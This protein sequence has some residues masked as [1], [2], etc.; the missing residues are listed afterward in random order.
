MSLLDP[1]EVPGRGDAAALSLLPAPRCG[2]LGFWQGAGP[3]P[4]HLL[5]LAPYGQPPPWL[6]PKGCGC[7][8]SRSRLQAPCWRRAAA[9]T[10]CCWRPAPWPPS[11]S[12]SG[13]QGAAALSAPLG[14]AA[15]WVHAA[16]TSIEG[17]SV[18]SQISKELSSQLG[19]RLRADCLMCSGCPALD[20]PWA[21]VI[22]IPYTCESLGCSA[23]G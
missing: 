22:R 12:A 10:V 4:W 23:E 1:R 5:R 6:R 19:T 11:V 17:L 8:G 14:R 3:F 20:L 18:Q 16:Q 9:A 15:G 7:S 2:C 13:G 21:V